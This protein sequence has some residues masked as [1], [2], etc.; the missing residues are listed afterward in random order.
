MKSRWSLEPF[1]LSTE[2]WLDVVLEI[3]ERSG[4]SA[5]VYCSSSLSERD[6]LVIIRCFAPRAVGANLL[7]LSDLLRARIAHARFSE[8]D[9]RFDLFEN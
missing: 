3:E 7:S 8:D 9:V 4:A 6:A 2:A 1:G 5:L